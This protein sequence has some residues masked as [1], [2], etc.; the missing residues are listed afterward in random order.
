MRKLLTALAI[1]AACTGVMGG[2]AAAD[3]QRA[4]SQAVAAGYA[5][6]FTTK[7]RCLEVRAYYDIFYT[8][9]PCYKNIK[10]FYFK[11]S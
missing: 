2:T 3:T 6:Y 8:V 9:G 10:G 5:G 11:Y 1:A 7:Q 4:D